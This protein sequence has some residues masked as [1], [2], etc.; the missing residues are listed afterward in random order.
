MSCL[1]RVVIELV[2]RG[3][4]VMYCNGIMFIKQT[5]IMYCNSKQTNVNI[6][7]GSRDTAM[8]SHLLLT[9]M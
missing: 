5:R 6:S 9:T 4:K 1:V 7:P 2:E 3:D 8:F